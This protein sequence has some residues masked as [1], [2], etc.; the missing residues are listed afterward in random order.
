M[1]EAAEP[2]HGDNFAA[3]ACT[4]RCHAASRSLLVEPKMRS[5]VMTV[6]DIPYFGEPCHD[7]A[8]KEPPRRSVH[9]GN[10]FAVQSREQSCFTRMAKNRRQSIAHRS[11]IGS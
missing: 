5:V 3:G 4:L 7:R 10:G 8:V 1:M 11:A 9:S 6:A 2:W